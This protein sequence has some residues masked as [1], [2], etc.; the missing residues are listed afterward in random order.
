MGFPKGQGIYLWSFRGGQLIRRN[1]VRTT[2]GFGIGLLWGVGGVA[3]L[4]LVSAAGLT[5]T[6]SQGIGGG[7][8]TAPPPS[9]FPPL[10]T[11]HHNH[12]SLPPADANI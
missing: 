3:E 1:T 6:D 4:N 10:L 11:K 5:I 7:K 2:G 8:Y 12:P 9:A